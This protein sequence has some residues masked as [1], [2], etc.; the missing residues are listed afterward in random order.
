MFTLLYTIFYFKLGLTPV[1]F[2]VLSGGTLH[3][4]ANIIAA[5]ATACSDAIDMAVI[6]KL[7][8][9]VMLVS[10]AILFGILKNRQKQEAKKGTSLPIPGFIV[11]FLLM[12][13]FRYS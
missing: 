9:V 11:G 2:G 3:E 10:V 4:V 5:S 8:I 6:V 12:S 1:Q 13:T 7:T